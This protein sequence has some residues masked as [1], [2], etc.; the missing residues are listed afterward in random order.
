MGGLA[1]SPLQTAV[2]L[3]GQ[4]AKGDP[5]APTAASWQDVENGIYQAFQNDNCFQHHA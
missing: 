5:K 3:L 1:A 4:F 2:I